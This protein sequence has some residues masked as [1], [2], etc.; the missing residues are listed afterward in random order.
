[1]SFQVVDLNADT[2]TVTKF[3]GFRIRFKRDAGQPLG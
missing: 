1:M 2:W 3:Q